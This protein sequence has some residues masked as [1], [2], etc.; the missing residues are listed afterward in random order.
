MRTWTIQHIR[1]I[2]RVGLFAVYVGFYT[3]CGRTRMLHTYVVVWSPFNHACYSLHVICRLCKH[4]SPRTYHIVNIRPGHPLEWA[5]SL[6]FNAH[7]WAA[8]FGWTLT[9]HR[10]CDDHHRVYDMTCRV[11]FTHTCR[12]LLH[13]PHHAHNLWVCI[14]CIVHVR[15]RVDRKCI[16]LYKRL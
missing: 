16:A 9:S 1:Y 5:L 3:Y 10:K 12:S 14:H 11:F 7:F 8:R 13:T 4:R 2:H 6:S 15:I